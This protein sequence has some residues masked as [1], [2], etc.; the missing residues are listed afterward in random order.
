MEDRQNFPRVVFLAGIAMGIT[1][2]GKRTP[3]AVPTAGDGEE[4][5]LPGDD[6]E[7]ASYGDARKRAIE[8]TQAKVDGV[9][10]RCDSERCERRQASVLTLGGLRG[11][12]CWS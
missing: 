6:V 12:T 7:H 1:H 9:E 5:S 2:G 10:G 3:Q 11:H 8:A 4:V